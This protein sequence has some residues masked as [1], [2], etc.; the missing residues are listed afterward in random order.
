MAMAVIM[1]TCIW[2]KQP[3]QNMVNYIILQRWMK[4][5]YFVDALAGHFSVISKDLVLDIE[6]P[7]RDQNFTKF[8]SKY[9]VSKTYGNMCITLAKN[10]QNKFNSLRCGTSRDIVFE[11]NDTKKKVDS[12][13]DIEKVLDIFKKMQEFHY[14]RVNAANSIQ[15][16][17]KYVQEQDYEN[18]KSI[19]K[20]AQ[21]KL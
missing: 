13:Q 4:L 2:K 10:I 5:T 16:A 19:L 9:T 3:D 21:D 18:N 14:L 15:K 20:D 12:I 1:I 6:I 8:L 17:L 7:I 11:I